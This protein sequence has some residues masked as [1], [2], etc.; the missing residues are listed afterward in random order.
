MLYKFTWDRCVGANM[1]GKWSSLVNGILWSWVEIWSVRLQTKNGFEKSD[2]ALTERLPDGAV[3]DEV[4]GGVEDQEE[5]VEG[6]QDD[7]GGRKGKPVLLGAEDIVVL[8]T[9]LR[10]HRLKN[11]HEANFRSVGAVVAAQRQS[12]S[13]V[14]HGSCI[15]IL[16]KSLALLCLAPSLHTGKS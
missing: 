1:G 10:V 13:L 5:V 4:D 12:S 16:L 3:D 2:D 7:E 9:L 14:I 11:G 8:E 15:Q 6:D